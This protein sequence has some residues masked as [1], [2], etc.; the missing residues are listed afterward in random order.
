MDFSKA[1]GVDGAFK[2]VLGYLVKVRGDR[3]YYARGHSQASRPRSCTE[4]QSGRGESCYSVAARYIDVVLVVVRGG[5]PVGDTVE[6]YVTG[7]AETQGYKGMVSCY[8]AY[9]CSDWYVI[10][11]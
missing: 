9:E 4:Q 6:G 3:A 1:S 5:A 10:Y 11:G 7:Y 2:E 8:E